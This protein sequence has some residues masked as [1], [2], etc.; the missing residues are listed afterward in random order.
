MSSDRWSGSGWELRQGDALRLLPEL[1]DDG[2][3]LVL[4]DCPYSSGGAYRGD[5]AQSTRAKYVTSERRDAYPEF[6]GDTRDQRA[7]GYWCSLWYGE[8]LRVAKPGA[9]CLSFTDWRQLPA[10]T[11]AY[12]AGGWVWR[13]IACWDKTEAARGQIGRFRAQAEFVVW[14]TK[15]PHRPY[16]GAP[17]LP[18]VIT[19]RIEANR[20]HIAQKPLELLLPLVRLAPPGGLVLDPFA[21]T[22]STGEAALQE[23]RRVLLFELERPTCELIVERLQ[24]FTAGSSLAASQQGQGALFGGQP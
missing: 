19:S 23:G 14:G 13:G 1:P 22:G 20:F 7:F 4:T 17:T 10:T 16:E 21:G 11:D 9:F 5:R 12:Q 24:S 18:G 2:V 6:A 15:G 8:L 3:D